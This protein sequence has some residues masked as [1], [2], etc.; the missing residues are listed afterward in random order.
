MAE[1]PQARPALLTINAALGIL[2]GAVGT[3]LL[4]YNFLSWFLGAVYFNSG[5]L[6]ID[7]F[8]VVVSAV[9][10]GY[11]LI[12]LTILRWGLAVINDQ[13]TMAYF[14]G[15]TARVGRYG[16]VTGALTVL[17]MLPFV[18]PFFIYPI[19]GSDEPIIPLFSLAYL[20]AVV[21]AVGMIAF[22]SRLDRG[23]NA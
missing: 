21:N 7:A 12:A 2:S 16:R 4:A 20:L 14:P 11:V 5:E 15:R 3:L 8:Y 19:F 17:A 23:S 22:A 1:T 13:P 6:V 9:A 10:S 18:I